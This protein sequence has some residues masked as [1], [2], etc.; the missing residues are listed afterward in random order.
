MHL[1]QEQDEAN[2][3]LMGDLRKLETKKHDHTKQTGKDGP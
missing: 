3:R 1:F 2:N